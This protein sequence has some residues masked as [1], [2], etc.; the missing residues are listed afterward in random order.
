MQEG[1]YDWPKRTDF[2]Q[3]SQKMKV[4][5]STYREHLKKAEKKILPDLIKQL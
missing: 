1:Y 2:Q 3:L 5:V 4:T